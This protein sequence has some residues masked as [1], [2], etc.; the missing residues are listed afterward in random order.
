MDEKVVYGLIQRLNLTPIAG[1]KLAVFLSGLDNQS[2]EIDD[3][4]VSGDQ[5]DPG[6]SGDQDEN[7]LI[8]NSDQ[9]IIN[10][11]K[12][13]QIITLTRPI[14]EL[15]IRA[16]TPLELNKAKSAGVESLIDIP[17]QISSKL[18]SLG[19]ALETSLKDFT[20][21]KETGTEELNKKFN[22]VVPPTGLNISVV[23]TLFVAALTVLVFVILKAED[24]LDSPEA[25]WGFFSAGILILLGIN[26]V[27]INLVKSLRFK[28][29]RDSILIEAK[30]IFVEKKY[31]KHS[32]FKKKIEDESFQIQKREYSQAAELKLKEI[33]R[34]EQSIRESL[35][36]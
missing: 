8:N 26:A 15:S 5:D 27:I 18:N 34:E 31:L 11:L 33:G 22:L 28:K 7:T 1:S 19:T 13:M 9:E 16:Q 4:G 35:N 23:L 2:A 14:L 36:A 20:E 10:W 17:E 21:I 32:K 25:Y 29:N 6:V 24:M 3:S 30:R 12:R